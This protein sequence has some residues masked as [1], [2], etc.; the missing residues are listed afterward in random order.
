MTSATDL[1]APSMMEKSINALL[2]FFPGIWG[3]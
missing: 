2:Y 1:A 3:N